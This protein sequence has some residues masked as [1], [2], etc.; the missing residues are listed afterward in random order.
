M[1]P[2]MADGAAQDAVDSAGAESGA[3]VILPD[4]MQP[5]HTLTRLT[6]P[7][8]RARTRWMFGFQRRLVRRCECDTDMP[9]E[10]FLPHTSHTEAMVFTD[11]RFGYFGRPREG[12]T[13]QRG[14]RGG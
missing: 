11:R 7:S 12:R 10:G 6:V 8:T 13:G 5:V 3:L 14:Y 9:H 4:L 2:C 1:T